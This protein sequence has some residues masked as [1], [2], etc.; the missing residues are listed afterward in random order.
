[1]AP[2]SG[3]PLLAVEG[4]CKTFRIAAASPPRRVAAVKDVDFT[5]HQNEFIGIVGESGSGKSTVARMLCGL[6]QASS[7]HIVIAGR[8]V[9]DGSSAS[10]AHMR[11]HVQMGFR[12][13]NRRSIRVAASP[14]S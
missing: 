12:I 8:E 3:T 1:M 11:A 6:E 9:S 4:L 7:G 2:D 10:H 5:L 13:R 14:A